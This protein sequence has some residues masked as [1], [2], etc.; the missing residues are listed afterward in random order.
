MADYI[1]LSNE[2]VSKISNNYFLEKSGHSTYQDEPTIFL[3][4]GQ[5]G[6]G[7]SNAAKLAKQELA[8]GG[9]IHVDADRMRE[10]IPNS[11]SFPSAATQADA[12]RLVMQL[13]QTA[14]QN[15]RNIVEEGTFR[16]AESVSRFIGYMKESGYRVELVA[17]ATSPEESLLGIYERYEQQHQSAHKNPLFVEKTYHDNTVEGFHQTLATQAANFDRVRV[18]NRAGEV[19]HDTTQ[20]ENLHAKPIDALVSGQQVSPDKL[21]GLIRG[22]Q[23]VTQR[24]AGRGAAGAYQAQVAEQLNYAQ[25]LHP[26]LQTRFLLSE[27]QSQQIFDTEIVPKLFANARTAS[28][29]H[30]VLL[31]GQPAA[32]KTKVLNQA[33]EEMRA[34]GGVVVINGDDFRDYHPQYKKLM[35]T[36]NKNAAFY[37]DR[38][39]G[40]WVEK[41]INYAQAQ[42]VNL[43]IEG[44]MR[45]PAVVAKT[46]TQLRTAGYMVEAIALAV[47]ERQS[48]Q[49]V[50][51]RY[52]A[53][54]E[55]S[56][57]ARFTAKSS[58]DAG[59]W[60]M[61]DTLNQIHAHKTVDK[62]TIKTR[63]GETLYQ[64]ELVGK[65]FWQNQGRAS[66][67]V[68]AFRARPATQQE[69]VAHMQGWDKIETM[70]KQRGAGVGELAQVKQYRTLDELQFNH[71]KFAQQMAVNRKFHGQMT[72][73]IAV[74]HEKIPKAAV[75]NEAIKALIKT[76][77]QA[78]P[79]IKNHQNT[80]Q[81]TLPTQTIKPKQ[82]QK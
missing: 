44:T 51:H 26:Q 75:Q 3:I 16:D 38:D 39:A 72:E 14:V 48:W 45:N 4:G 61:I 65:D 1:P 69:A 43:V 47:P 42:R 17:L 21:D 41:S 34:R 11:G 54:L 13:R 22:W 15:H 20:A 33:A 74:I 46:A 2:E 8:A 53:S 55:Q 66:E 78:L 68:L 49:G 9:Y 7:K 50:H 80:G 30:A 60:G 36:D 63:Q 12:G 57:A 29:P 31:G 6:A 52:E 56:K 5:S 27:Q 70:M 62:I 77:E 71:P 19:L 24:A 59:L 81:I 23:Q 82:T 18:L 10:F 28:Q 76:T 40:R 73:K 37:T 25:N 79:Q 58:H 35:A 67:V 64:N 32:G